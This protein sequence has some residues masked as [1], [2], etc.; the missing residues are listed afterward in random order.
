MAS[1]RIVFQA[2]DTLYLTSGDFH[3]DGM[4][5]DGELIAQNPEAEYG[6]VLKID[7]ATGD[8]AIVS[9]GHR[10]MQGMTFTEDGQLFVAEHGPNGGDE[11]NSSKR[12]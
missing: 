10:N 3:W 4:R 2:P 5:A 11:L 12:A 9:M 1:G 7:L 6:K 8:S